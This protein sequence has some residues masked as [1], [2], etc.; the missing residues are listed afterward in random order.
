MRCMSKCYKHM[1][2]KIE[3]REFFYKKVNLR[4]KV[5]TLKKKVISKVQVYTFGKKK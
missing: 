2:R 4:V 3:E 1:A 5:H